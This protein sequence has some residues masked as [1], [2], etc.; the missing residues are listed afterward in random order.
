M[1]FV[2]RIR[3]ALGLK[4]KTGCDTLPPVNGK[5]G[6]A[7]AARTTLQ[8]T[9]TKRN[10]TKELVVNETGSPRDVLQIAHEEERAAH[11]TMTDRLRDV[12]EE[13]SCLADEIAQ[14]AGVE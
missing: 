13:A 9:V 8:F 6:H 14:L 11:K 3:K 10:G 7:V 1:R 4:T 2:D 12:Y 5:A